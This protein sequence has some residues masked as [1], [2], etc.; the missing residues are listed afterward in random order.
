MTGASA[1]TV[2]AHRWHRAQDYEALTGELQS[3]NAELVASLHP[4]PAAVRSV[5]EIGCGTGAL[6]AALVRALP[7]ATIEAVD[8]SADML[9]AAQRKAWPERVYFRHAA[10][11]ENAPRV[12]YDAVFSNAA[13]HWTYP[14]YVETFGAIRTLLRPGGLLCAAMAGRTR[15]T[16]EF[17]ETVREAIRGVTAQQA[18]DDFTRRRIDV[19][20]AEQLA[21]RANLAV[22]DAFVV[23][24]RVAVDADVYARWWIASGG[25]WQ[26]H[27]VRPAEAVA[28]VT[29]A[30]GGPERRLSLVHASVLMRLRR[31]EDQAHA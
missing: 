28:L 5:Y 23:E 10:F 14:R 9:A 19:D 11:P 17:E 7:A 4:E 20:A 8:V 1:E 2:A 16:D 13:L 18:P 30:L 26:A 31:D 22:E 25:P 29:D 27:Q 15:A 12:A 21:A 24:R 6:T 3:R